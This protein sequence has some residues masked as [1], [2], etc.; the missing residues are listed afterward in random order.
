MRRI[1]QKELRQIQ[2][3]ILNSVHQFCIEKGLRYSLGGG[4]LLGA[5]RHRGYIPWDDDIDIMMPRP[6]YNVFV[7][8]FNGYKPNLVCSAY[9]NDKTFIYPYAKVYDDRTYLEYINCKKA[10]AVNIDLFPIDG[11]PDKNKNK[12]VFK[13]FMF[14][15]KILL[16]MLYVKKQKK[17]SWKKTLFAVIPF[18]MVQDRVYRLQRTYRIEDSNFTGCV[19]GR[20]FEKE[21]YPRNV[22]EEY[23]ELEFEN[24]QFMA[25]KEYDVFLSGHYGDYMKLPPIDQQTGHHIIDAFWMK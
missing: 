6:D 13:I 25:I 18:P 20:Y 9:E 3:D 12:M 23:I 19:T 10:L 2:T 8:E 24:R 22:F 21:C 16:T 17:N 7:R 1:E 14:R 15:L 5:V 4:T 11:F